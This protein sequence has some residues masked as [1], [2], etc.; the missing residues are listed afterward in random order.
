[1]IT[2]KGAIV[3][4]EKVSTEKRSQKKKN[5]LE[6]REEQKPDIL[7]DIILKCFFNNQPVDKKK[8]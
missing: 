6:K 5:E 1:M 4:S 7:H 2:C 8:K 3:N